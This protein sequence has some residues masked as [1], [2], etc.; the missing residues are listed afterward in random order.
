MP[1][2]FGSLWK[3][4][5]QFSFE[6]QSK[7]F[8][9]LQG[10]LRL[11]WIVFRNVQNDLQINASNI[12]KA[13]YL[14]IQE[15]VIL[16][17]TYQNAKIY[18]EKTVNDLVKQ[19]AKNTASAYVAAQ[20]EK[21]LNVKEFLTDKNTN[22]REIDQNLIHFISH[23]DIHFHNL[24]RISPMGK[25]LRE[26][27]DRIALAIPFYGATTDV[28]PPT[29]GIPPIY[30]NPNGG[31]ELLYD[32]ETLFLN[33]EGQLTTVNSAPHLYDFVAPLNLNHY[34]ASLLYNP[35]DFNLNSDNQLSIINQHKSLIDSVSNPLTITD[36]NL[37]LNYNPADFNLNTSNQLSII[38]QHKSVI[39]TVSDPFKIT[40]KNL[41][42]NL[43]APLSTTLEGQLGLQIGSHLG[44][45]ADGSLDGLPYFAVEPLRLTNNVEFSLG[46]DAPLYQSANQNLGIRI[47]NNSITLNAQNQLQ[48]NVYANPVHP[49]YLNEASDLTLAFGSPLFMNPSNELTLNYTPVFKLNNQQQLD[50]KFAKPLILDSNHALSLNY[51]GGLWLSSNQLKINLNA[52]GGNSINS[53]NEL[54]NNVDGSTI[55]INNS[56]A[57][58]LNANLKT[59]ITTSKTK[60]AAAEQVLNKLSAKVDTNKTNI[61]NNTT[62]VVKAINDVATLSNIISTYKTDIDLNNAFRNKLK[63]TNQLLSQINNRLTILTD[64]SKC[65]DEIIFQDHYRF[66]NKMESGHTRS[67]NLY[68]VPANKKIVNIKGSFFIQFNGTGYQFATFNLNKFQKATFVTHPHN[69]YYAT[70]IGYFSSTRDNPLLLRIYQEGNKLKYNI[71]SNDITPNEGYNI[72]CDFQVVTC[73][74][75]DTG[76]RSWNLITGDIFLNNVEWKYKFPN[77]LKLTPTE[78]YTLSWI[79]NGALYT[80]STI[81][82]S[83]GTWVSLYL[84]GHS[85]HGWDFKIINQHSFS[86]KSADTTPLI[87]NLVLNVV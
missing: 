34:T 70:Y 46:Y 36:R 32:P 12:N 64:T 73:D 85:G 31:I 86:I 8:D 26:Y 27:R 38:N 58:S 74:S 62:K 78:T 60:I 22:D 55:F 49:L 6:L 15:W 9:P 4:A 39:E 66:Q 52:A 2:L 16:S 14:T 72:E 61:T 42:L 3:N 80:C 30:T 69:L 63:Y 82:V 17:T 29:I 47:D 35:N 25:L 40:N 68:T 50:L 84:N 67:D 21:T 87:Q 65:S 20:E 51:S 24:A 7:G 13:K 59:D 75:Q 18:F 5:D 79:Y 53:Y 33:A 56:N 37:T 41:S 76:R 1:I 23:L 19:T 43:T 77:N 71:V 28:Q 57:L 48:A 44:L 83:F 54:V 81:R 45:N 10:E 11:W